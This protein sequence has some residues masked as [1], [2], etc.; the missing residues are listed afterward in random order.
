MRLPREVAHALAQGSVGEVV[1]VQEL[2]LN[3]GTGSATREV[4][5]VDVAIPAPDGQRAE[6]TVVRKTLAPVTSGRHAVGAA[7]P[8]HWAYWRREAEAYRSNLLPQG[9]GLRAPRCWGVVGDVIYLEAVAGAPASAH[10]AAEHL[11]RWH[12]GYDPALDR[13][14]LARDQIGQRLSVTSLDWS[15][16]NVDPR[17]V[18]LW[19]RREELEAELWRLPLAL[20]HGDFGIGN[21]LDVDGDT[22]AL[23]WATLGW[24]PAGFDLAHLA[25]S[26]GIDPTEPYE[27]A[28]AFDPAD[29]RAGY[30]AALTIVGISRLHWMISQGRQIPNYYLDLLLDA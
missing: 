8:R 23:D 17:V 26:T 10:Q 11:A 16:L 22:V 20:S 24:E 21:L 9:P 4:V 14:W 6:Q 19:D 7:N 15:G 13:P 27:S 12:A 25:L 5:L 18:Q 28:S 30:R 29:I 2:I 1:V 3:G